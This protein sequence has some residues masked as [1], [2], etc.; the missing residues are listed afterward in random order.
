MPLLKSGLGGSRLAPNMS[1]S[2]LAQDYGWLEGFRP[3][4]RI[5]VNRERTKTD[6]DA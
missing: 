2:G 5:G 4:G 3:R 1:R 6:Q